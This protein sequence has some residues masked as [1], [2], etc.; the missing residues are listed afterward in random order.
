MSSLY[1]LSKSTFNS[2]FNIRGVVSL[3][4]D[5]LDTG[6]ILNPLPM[7]SFGDVGNIYVETIVWKPKF[8]KQN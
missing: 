2:I 3:G 4:I 6:K 7:V 8:K 1:Y 5:F